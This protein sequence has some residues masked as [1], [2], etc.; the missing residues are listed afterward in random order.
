MP[1]EIVITPVSYTP[2]CNNSATEK[3]ALVTDID[4]KKY[5]NDK[6]CFRINGINF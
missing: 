6:Y 1:E 5:N 3:I 2:K 4:E